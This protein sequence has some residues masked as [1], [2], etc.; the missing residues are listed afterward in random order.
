MSAAANYTA[1]QA[2]DMTFLFGIYDQSCGGSCHGQYAAPPGDGNWQIADPSELAKIDQSVINHATSDGPSP[3]FAPNDVT[4][5]KDPMPPTNSPGW[6]PYSQR[7]TS[8]PVVLF[9]NIFQA[10]INQGQPTPSFTPPDGVI[11][12]SVD[13]FTNS[14]EVALDMTNIGNC[15]PDALSVAQS[16]SATNQ[17]TMS[18]LDTM[19]ENSYSTILLDAGGPAELG[20]PPDLINTDLTTF[21]SA[22]LAAQ[23]VIAYQPT[24]PNWFDDAAFLRYV[25]VPVGQSIQF[26]K[27]TQSFAI[28]DNTRFYQTVLK[29][30]ADVDG[31]YRWRKMETRLLVV[32]NTSTPLLGTYFWNNGDD[33]T[34]PNSPPASE[35]DA[36]LYTA[37][38]N[39]LLPF[40][41]DTRFFKTDEQLAQDILAQNPLNPE[42][43]LVTKGA[44]KHYAV[45]SSDQCGACHMGSPTGNYVLGFTPLQLNRRAKG[46]GGVRDTPGADEMTQLQRF[47]DYGLIT[48]MSSPADVLPLEQAEGDRTPRNDYEL[49]AQAYMV[50]NCAHCHNPNGAATKNNPELNG[51]LNFMPGPEGG[52]FQ[53][54]L[55]KY[56]PRIPRGS[57]SNIPIPYIS[58]SLLDLG[59]CAKAS[60]TNLYAPWRSLIFRA[61]DTPFPYTT[62]G[63]L[64]PHM[65]MNGAGFDCTAK[66][67]VSDWMVSIPAVR[68]DPQ[69]PEYGVGCDDLPQPY[70]EVPPGT[71]GYAGAVQSAQQ[72]LSILH[73]G[74]NPLV[75]SASEVTPVS[76]YAHCPDTEDILDPAVEYSPV[77][78]P[79]PTPGSYLVNGEAENLSVV[80]GHAQWIAVDT[81]LAS[82]SW[83]PVRG[84]WA[85]I[86]INKDFQSPLPTCATPDQL[87]AQAAQDEEK[88]AVDEL[89]DAGVDQVKQYAMQSIPMGLWEVH[90]DCDMSSQQTVGDFRTANAGAGANGGA[91]GGFTSNWNW[92][93]N[94]NNLPASSAP[95]VVETPGAYVY[96]QIC[97][98]C[99]GANADG[100]GRLATNLTLMTAGRGIPSNFVAGM[101]GPPTSPGINEL[102]NFALLPTMDGG[103]SPWST[104]SID[105][106]GARYLAWMGLGGTQLVIPAPVVQIV[107]TT[108]VFGLQRSIPQSLISGNMLSVAKALCLS[109]LFGTADPT[110]MLFHATSGATPIDV[111]KVWFTTD[112]SGNTLKADS[113]LFASN[114]DAELWR[115]VC[116]LANPP[117]VRA[118][119]GSLDSAFQ[120]K[121]AGG[122][123]SSLQPYSTDLFPPELYGPNPVGNDQGAIDQDGIHPIDG[124]NPNFQP[125]C[126]RN[127]S[128]SP[129]ELPKCPSTIDDGSVSMASVDLNILQGGTT[130]TCSTTTQCW[131]PAEA[132]RWATRGAIN[133]GLVVY[134]YLQALANPTVTNV[135]PPT[136]Y[137][138]CELLSPV[139]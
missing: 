108:A 28:P 32:R 41:A 33:S 45:L 84:D 14:P 95:V 34:T 98:N 73:T 66:Q 37:V 70:V 102:L 22:K 42:Y 128:S 93:T 76:E 10:W 86:L 50:G 21:D 138:R 58:P 13:N 126:Y 89:Q 113:N 74:T 115:S 48:G 5:P 63:A 57:L 101:F 114:G 100:H 131:G 6:I 92:L 7:L 107:S 122:A 61:V 23:G 121:I 52:I 119:Y 15:V 43:Q 137:N 20:L 60:S 19:F 39:N 94:S 111:E 71:A 120:D 62:D 96:T 88:V 56:S 54:P 127:A 104:A 12:P 26:N 129:E 51:V 124:P 77:C 9:V 59:T 18:A 55:Q 130:P 136:P 68:S 2:V 135:T 35:S 99:H 4:D 72:R 24:Y 103:A 36:Q 11:P 82:T 29:R 118:L 110:A 117:P 91:A 105:D 97:A 85:S 134:L 38:R 40:K 53:F 27:A 64:F 17:A 1:G 83:D 69:T 78:H 109:L 123:D 132:D 79:V 125:W 31:S 44:G 116:T 112:P 30:I 106:R 49:A 46:E 8:D 133:T 75:A 90:S 25:R 16:R 81:T 139:Q 47:I 65:P 67:I 3:G 80:P 87:A